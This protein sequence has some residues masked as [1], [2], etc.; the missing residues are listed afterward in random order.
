MGTS[1][2]HFTW[3]TLSTMFSLLS[4]GLLAVTTHALPAA[5]PQVGLPLLGGPLLYHA[6]N[7][8]T[9][10]DTITTKSCKPV[11]ENVCED[12]EIPGSKIE[13]EDNC[14]EH[15]VQQCGLQPVE[16][17]AEADG[18]EVAEERKRREAEADPQ[19]ITYGLPFL[20]APV[21]P[22]LK[23]V[24]EETTQEYC[25]PEAK[26]V[27]VTHTVQ[28]CLLKTSVECEDVEHKIPRVV[29]APTPLPALW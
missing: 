14:S 10:E 18:V 24:C 17:E 21:V 7:C 11:T 1:G 25:F 20:P 15:T 22:L 16:P 19:L 26:V 9:E 4:L 5:D 12:I 13:Y 27:Q 3:A 29:C 2:K 28:R 6:P 8:T 23:H